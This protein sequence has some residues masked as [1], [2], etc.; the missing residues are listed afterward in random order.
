MAY[1]AIIGALLGGASSIYGQSQQ[2][3]AAKDAQAA[4][5][6]AAAQGTKTTSEMA[7]WIQ[8][9]A[10][11]YLERQWID[12]SKPY[13]EYGGFFQNMQKALDAKAAKQ[14]MPWDSLFGPG[15]DVLPGKSTG[16]IP[17]E[18]MFRQAGGIPFNPLT[19][20]QGE[21]AR[22]PLA[23]KDYTRYLTA[24]STKG[25][26]TID[27]IGEPQGKAWNKQNKFLKKYMDKPL[28]MT[29][30]AL[31]AGLLN[32]QVTGMQNEQAP[33]I[34]DQYYAGNILR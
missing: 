20:R 5:N 10:K 12:S 28:A 32:Y 16:M 33:S 21:Q 4:A 7:S 8:P 25:A 30:P 26:N 13:Q 2:Q 3:Q 31:T 34:W 1:G 14:P 18:L 9:Y 19:A 17:D 29:S 15:S 11:A 27:A 23:G 22:L 6:A 24:L